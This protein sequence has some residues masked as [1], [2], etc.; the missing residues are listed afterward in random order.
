MTGDDRESALLGGVFLIA[1]GAA[2][3][4][5]AMR[6]F[7]DPVGAT[8]AIVGRLG[9][10]RLSKALRPDPRAHPRFIRWNAVAVGIVGAVFAVVGAVFVASV[11]FR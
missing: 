8:N 6:Q 7:R 3:T 4:A 2:I 5:L 10:K 1:A 9:G 11:V